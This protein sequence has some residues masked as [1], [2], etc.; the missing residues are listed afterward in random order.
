MEP[1]LAATGF[2]F[3]F[4]RPALVPAHRGVVISRFACTFGNVQGE[5]D[6]GAFVLC[7]GT[8]TWSQTFKRS[9]GSTQENPCPNV[10]GLQRGF[11]G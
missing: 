4:V 2:C 3:F 10:I 5:K 1:I 11:G 6:L 9:M 7:V 8:S